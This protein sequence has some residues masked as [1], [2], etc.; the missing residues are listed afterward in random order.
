M[1]EPG[2]SRTAESAPSAESDERAW[3]ALVAA[4][5]CCRDDDGGAACAIGPGPDGAMARLP[6]ETGEALCRF[7]PARGWSPGPA[8]TAEQRV[9]LDLYLPFCAARP[10]APLT[11][12][13]LGQSLDGHIATESGDS[14]YVTG[15]VNLLHLHRMR[16]LSDAVLVGAETIAK[17]DP[18]LTTRL[19]PGDNAVRVVI[20]PKRR[21]EDRFRVFRDGQAPTLLVCDAR[22]ADGAGEAPGRV[23]V[24]GVPSER[25]RLR[26]DRLL[27][28]LHARGIHAVFVEGGGATVSSFLEG[29]LLD[30]IQVTIAPLITG[31]GRSGLCLPGRARLGDALR[32]AH[33]IFR[34]GND[35]LFDCDLRATANAPDG[36]GALARIL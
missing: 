9:L 11:I 22:Y 19:A 2:A 25:G 17:D 27:E 5:R 13:H 34:M 14:Y 7:E 32:P 18:R 8:A 1:T 3:A 4:A 28:R 15:P 12:G 31:A 30:R 6:A 26:L 29:E 36:D 23:S 33:R 10:G 24:V 16:A 21:L 20:D 35:V